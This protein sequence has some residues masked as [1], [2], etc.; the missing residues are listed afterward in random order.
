ML[1]L[2]PAQQQ[3]LLAHALQGKER[4]NKN[5]KLKKKKKYLSIFASLCLVLRTLAAAPERMDVC[6]FHSNTDAKLS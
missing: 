2:Q 3:I 1:I 4:T 6:L 5:L